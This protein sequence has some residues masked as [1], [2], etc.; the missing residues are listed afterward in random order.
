[1]TT[2]W[3]FK[4]PADARVLTT[5]FVLDKDFPIL[6][7]LHHDGGWEFLCGTTE[8]AKDAREI[9]LGEA[10]EL[11]PRLHEVADLPVGWR[12][13]RDSPE[14]PWMQEPF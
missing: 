1:V 9:L 5:R 3:P 4:E 6:I 12:A 8:K 11:D 10:V 2:A 14:A 7:V 13:F